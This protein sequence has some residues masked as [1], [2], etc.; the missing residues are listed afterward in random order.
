MTNE[1]VVLKLYY[2]GLNSCD[3]AKS[4]GIGKKTVLKVLNKYNLKAHNTKPLS[5]RKVT[6]D[7]LTKIINLY[8]DGFTLT[9]IV[10]LLKLDCSSSAI[11]SLLIRRGGANEKQRKAKQF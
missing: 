8:N 6:D 7:E 3:I 11:R 2:D 1:S 10:S 5:P 9:K 4:M